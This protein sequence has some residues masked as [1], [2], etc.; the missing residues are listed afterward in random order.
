MGKI[1]KPQAIFKISQVLATD[2]RGDE[3]LKFDSLDQY[4]S[5]LDIIKALSN[6]SNKHGEQFSNPILGKRKDDAS[7]GSQRHEESDRNN[8]DVT[9][10]VN[11]DKFLEGISKES[12][13]DLG[14]GDNGSGDK[15]EL[16][17]ENRM[18]EQ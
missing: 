3:Q 16:E 9:N 11:V 12:E 14:G 2:Q 6:Q 17:S 5:T 8:G 10:P 4:A 18:G 13:F 15:S 7:G 1:K